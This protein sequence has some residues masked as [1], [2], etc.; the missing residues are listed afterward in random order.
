MKRT[1]FFILGFIL[2][3]GSAFSIDLRPVG[4]DISTLLEEIGKETIPY[5]QQNALIGDGMGLA[6]YSNNTGFYIAVT[7]AVVLS[8]GI[9]KFLDKS[10]TIFEVVNVGSLM[11]SALGESGPL[12]SLYE[13]DLFPYPFIRLNVGIALPSNFEL[14]LIFSAFPQFVTNL[15]ADQIGFTGLTFS[16]WNAG[17]RVRKPLVHDKG[18][19]PAI[20]LGVGYTFSNFNFGIDLPDDFSQ[21]LSGTPLSVSGA[22]KINTVLHTFGVD[23]ALSKKLSFFVPFIKLS[24][25]YQI[26]TYDGKVE[27]FEAVAGVS[28]YTD[29]ADEDPGAKLTLSDLAFLATGGFELLFGKFAILASGN[30]S[31]DTNS[32]GFNFGLRIGF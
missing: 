23:L 26:A 30:Y 27:D 5:L 29:Q 18:G 17:V 2:V 15:F 14:N 11:D 1:A 7:P 20:S 22:F 25:Y 12:K 19:F 6:E 13:S 32:F 31:F 8:S 21:D 9:G 3:C 28:R 10:D 4:R 16:R 24:S